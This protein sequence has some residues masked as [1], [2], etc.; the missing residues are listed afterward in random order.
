MTGED[1]N[2]VQINGVHS[3]A[4]CTEIGERLQISLKAGATRLPSHLKSLMKNLLDS[5]GSCGASSIVTGW[6]RK[7]EISTSRDNEM[8][9]LPSANRSRLNRNAEVAK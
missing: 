1:R 6:G 7:K 2:G 9:Q 8:P 4:I 3:G 5:V